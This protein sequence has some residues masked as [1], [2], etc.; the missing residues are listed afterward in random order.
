MGKPRG[1]FQVL[2]L[3]EQNIAQNNQHDD[4]PNQYTEAKWRLFV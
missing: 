1:Q 3:N 4:T 2:V